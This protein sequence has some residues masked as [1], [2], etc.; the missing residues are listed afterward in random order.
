MAGIVESPLATAFLKNTLVSTALYAGLHRERPDVSDAGASEVSGPGYARVRVSFAVMAPRLAR[1]TQAVRF[2]GLPQGYVSWV[3]IH[4]GA[5]GGK[6][7]LSI[8]MPQPT[9]IV[10]GVLELPA[11]AIYVRFP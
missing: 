1:S 6:L 11:D 9:L 8:P 5:T 2:T 7:W 4:T 3:G 10:G